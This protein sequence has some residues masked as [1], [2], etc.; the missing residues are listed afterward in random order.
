L[1][2]AL[3]IFGQV[4]FAMEARIIVILTWWIIYRH[5]VADAATR[6]APQPQE[7]KG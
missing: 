2:Y 4:K 6:N 3:D 1:L 5:L 7:N